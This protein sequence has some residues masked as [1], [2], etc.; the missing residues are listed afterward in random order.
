MPLLVHGHLRSTEFESL[1]RLPRSWLPS[2]RD[3]HGCLSGERSIDAMNC[4]FSERGRRHGGHLLETTLFEALYCQ[5]V[6]VSIMPSFTAVCGS[7]TMTGFSTADRRD[8]HE[9][10]PTETHIESLYYD[11]VI[12]NHISDLPHPLLP[13]AYSISSSQAR[14]RRRVTCE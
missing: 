4:L 9:Y 11:R 2:T 1:G 10:W 13:G 7:K 6:H 14:Q 8:C 3:L 12:N 5:A